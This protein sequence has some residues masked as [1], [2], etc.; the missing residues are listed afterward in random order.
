MSSA[1]VNGLRPM[2]EEQINTEKMLAEW[3]IRAKAHGSTKC[4]CGEPISRQYHIENKQTG[5]HTIIGIICARNFDKKKVKAELKKIREAERI[6]ICGE[7]AHRLVHGGYYHSDCISM[8]LA[9]AKEMSE[10][11]FGEHIAGILRER[12][13]R[14]EFADRILRLNEIARKI[15]SKVPTAHKNFVGNMITAWTIS[16][17][18]EKYLTGLESTYS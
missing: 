4:I 5:K 1:L 2:S 16:P 15:V 3:T 12:Q 8:K 10:K 7:P 6:C 14:K 9:E 11:E 17:A 13:A 18:Q